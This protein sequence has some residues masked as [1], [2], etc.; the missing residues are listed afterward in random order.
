MGSGWGTPCTKEPV[1]SRRR[2]RRKFKAF[3]MKGG[4]A[5]TTFK[6]ARGMLRGPGWRAWQV[7]GEPLPRQRPGPSP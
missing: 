6:E 4:R 1:T 5:G 2:V 3:L 7:H